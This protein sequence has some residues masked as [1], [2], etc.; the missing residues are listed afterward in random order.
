MKIKRL[1]SGALVAVSLATVI[2]GCGKSNEVNKN[3]NAENTKI[4][5]KKNENKNGQ[6]DKNEASTKVYDE[7]LKVLEGKNVLETKEYIVK[8]IE[9]VSAE[10]ADKMVGE[11]ELLIKANY[12]ELID[13]FNSPKYFNAVNETKD[14]EYNLQLEAIKDEEIKKE[15]MDVVASGYTFEMAE[16]DYYLAMDYAM[17]NDTFGKYL[18]EKI[19]PYY[20]I[21]KKELDKPTFVEEYLNIEFDEIKNRVVTLESFI[22][23]NNDF[24]NIEDAKE[25]MRW[26][27]QA[28]LTVDHFN[29]TVDYETGEVKEVVKNTYEELK[30]SDLKIIKEAVEEMDKFLAENNYVLKP[31][32]QE[33]YN[34]LFEIKFKLIDEV[35]DKVEEY[36]FKN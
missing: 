30:S 12:M 19:K 20:E 35:S 13:K 31:D 32:N 10:I 34:K 8:N 3:K 29:S 36:Y 6:A 1:V 22:K 15:V 11:Y 25:M 33:A 5:N 16:G 4:E 23:N 7:F 24:K 17:I 21:R 18:S 28:L 9:N 26:Y 27:V 14:E 2:T